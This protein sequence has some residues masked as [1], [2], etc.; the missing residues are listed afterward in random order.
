MKCNDI[1][2]L[3]IEDIYDEITSD[4]KKL[5]QK[6]LEKCKNCSAEYQ[7]LKVT[8]DTLKLWKDEKPETIEIPQMKPEHGSGRQD[9]IF[10]QVEL[11]LG[12]GSSLTHLS[13]PRNKWIV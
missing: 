7:E 10:H 13:Y 1:Q 6:H 5:L 8:S 11:F 3:M 12:L 2:S 4:N 9:C